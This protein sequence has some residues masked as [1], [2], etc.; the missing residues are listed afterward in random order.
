MGY[1]WVTNKREA[2]N[3]R[4]GGSGSGGRG[5]ETSGIRRK[6]LFLNEIHFYH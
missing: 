4:E 2:I 3:K 5:V 1:S 6:G